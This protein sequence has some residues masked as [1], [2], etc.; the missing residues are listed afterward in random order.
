VLH[1]LTEKQMV[2]MKRIN[3]IL[4]TIYLT[5]ELFRGIIWSRAGLVGSR[6]KTYKPSLGDSTLT[7]AGGLFN[8]SSLPRNV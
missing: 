5:T 6:D 4:F 8:L 3:G 2:N 7:A 1:P